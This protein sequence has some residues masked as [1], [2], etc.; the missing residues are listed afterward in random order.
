M[1]SIVNAANIVNPIEEVLDEIKISNNFR[2]YNDDFLVT[3]KFKILLEK[4]I[5]HR[6]SVNEI[7]N[8]WCPTGRDVYIAKGIERPGNKVRRG[9][10]TFGRSAGMIGE[11]F[12]MG[13]LEEDFGREI[14]YAKLNGKSDD[15]LKKF[16][17]IKSDDLNSLK[18][19]SSGDFIILMSGL[20]L[21][22]RFESSISSLLSNIS[23]DQHLTI[24]DILFKETIQPTPLSG[25]SAESKPDFMIPKLKLVGDV[26]SAESLESAHLLTCAGYALAYENWKRED[27]NWGMIYFFK[28][29]SFQKYGSYISTPQVCLFPI[30]D[31]LR[32][33]FKE[34]RDDFLELIS[35]KEY[36]K[37][38]DAEKRSEFCRTCKYRSF[39]KKKGLEIPDDL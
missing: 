22:G 3:G 13:L 6:L 36:P 27:I 18:R 33:W 7:S 17:A 29:K 1:Y 37:F 15:Y 21:G 28:G 8:R 2:G 24:E 26:K 38:P 32:S 31:N 35:Q 4:N 11:D 10:S 14:S 34:M 19:R 25:L 30:S 9:D 20:K 12:F 5:I 16:K 39:C 23:G